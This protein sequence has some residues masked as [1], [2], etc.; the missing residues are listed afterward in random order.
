MKALFIHDNIFYKLHDK[1][2]SIG[3]FNKKLWERYLNHFKKLTVIGRGI[4][5]QRI[6]TSLVLSSRENVT[7][8]LLYEIRG[9]KDYYLK[10]KLI[11]NKLI[12]HVLSHEFI[13]IRMPSAIGLI[14]ASICKI[15]RKP[16]IVEVVGCVWNSNWYYGGILPK[17]IAPYNY[18]MTRKIIKHSMAAIYVTKYYLQKRYPTNGLSTNISNVE[19]ELLD[20]ELFNKKL[21]KYDP[22]KTI[23]IGIGGSFDVKYKGQKELLD[24]LS[25]VKN[26]IPPFNVEMIGPGD[27]SW[28]L[29]YSRKIGLNNYVSFLGQLPGTK[30]V[31]EWI[32]TLDIYI[33]P[34]RTEGLPRLII[35]AM[36]RGCPVLASAVGGIPELLDSKY[37]HKPGNIRKLSEDI[38]K[39]LNNPRKLKE[40]AEMNFN[41]AKEYTSK[42]LNKRRNEFWN[43]LITTY[44]H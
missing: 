26:K 2:Y 17:I 42:V 10:S 22:L 30:S 13:I 23:K 37:L 14:A 18:F 33:H 31:L 1:Y 15:Y 7:F 5:L 38:M 36:S 25:L 4:E 8:D 27:F 34:S 39:Y 6:D 21:Q 24:A 29:N 43:K 44:N 20:Y 3:A 32:D 12:N 16:Y 19:I 9:G 11:S 40:M 28:L 35:E 41:K